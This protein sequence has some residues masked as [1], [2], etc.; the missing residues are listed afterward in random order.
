MS[1]SFV[2]HLIEHAV[3]IPIKGRQLLLQS[4]TTALRNL[5]P[6]PNN[7]IIYNVTTGQYEVYDRVALAWIALAPGPVPGPHAAT[8]MPGGA[9]LVTDIDIA[10]T[11]VLLSGHRARHEPGGADIVRD[12]DILG[13][14]VLLSGHQARHVPGAADPLPVGVP[15]NIGVA[16]AQGVAADFVRRDHVHNHP[17]GLGADLHHPQIHA[18]THIVGAGDPLQVG[19]PSNIG[20]ANAAGAATD[21]VRRDHVHAHPD[22]SG[23]VTPAHAHADLSG[24]T[25]WQHHAHNY[26]W[27]S[28]IDILIEIA[29]GG[30]QAFGVAGRV[31]TAPIQVPCSVTIDRI[32][33]FTSG[34]AAGNVRLSLYHVGSFGLPDLPDAGALVVES[35]SVAL[36][37]LANRVYLGTVAN[38]ALTPGLYFGAI[39]GDTVGDGYRGS[40]NL[41]NNV[42]FTRTYDL[43]G[44][45]PFTN[46][47]PATVT[48]D[49]YTPFFMLRVT[50]TP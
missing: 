35:A 9:D 12:I 21:F 16:N 29:F 11:G 47:C 24:V 3:F 37:G 42:S 2:R 28:N 5:L 32:G 50:S 36:G 38:T 22:L 23:L 7:F 14:G 10:A 44:Y 40:G 33:F 41:Y 26:R 45:G 25:A 1:V 13:T 15:L 46:P 27:I 17:A 4:L 8:H 20:A 49:W 31:F 48:R 18:P 39:Q 19:V 30:N 6:V 34:V 43:G